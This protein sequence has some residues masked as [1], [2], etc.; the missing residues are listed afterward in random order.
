[1]IEGYLRANNMFVDYKEVWSFSSF[2]LPFQFSVK[3]YVL[4]VFRCLPKTQPQQERAYSSYLE[5]NLDEVEPC[6]SGP[7]RYLLL[8]YT[9]FTYEF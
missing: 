8:A 2:H 9:C 4:T 5:L 6:V 3:D 7:K 1:M